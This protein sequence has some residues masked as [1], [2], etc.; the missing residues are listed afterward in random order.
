MTLEFYV[1]VIPTIPDEE[2]RNLFGVA[3][4]RHGI[5]VGWVVEPVFLHEDTAQEI[6]DHLIEIGYMDTIL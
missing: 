5:P 6:C 3:Y 4:R 1:A 2:R